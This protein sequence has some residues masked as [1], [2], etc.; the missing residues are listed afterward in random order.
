MVS[1]LGMIAGVVENDII[2]PRGWA[3]GAAMKKA[4]EPLS[5]VMSL[6]SE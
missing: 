1:W 5:R 6:L 4:H 2:Q 3:I